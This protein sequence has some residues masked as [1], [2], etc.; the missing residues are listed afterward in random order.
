[1]F[2]GEK[3][4]KSRMLSETS[5]RGKSIALIGFMGAGKSTVGRL[6]AD[7]LGMP[8]LDLD[9]EIERETGRDVSEIFSREGEEG[10]RKRESRALERALAEGGVVIACGGGVVTVEENVA[11]LRERAVVFCL[12]V[13]LEEALRR[14][15]EGGK[16][17]PLLTGDDPAARARRL[18]EQRKEAYAA[19]AHEVIRADAAAPEEIAEEIARRWRRYG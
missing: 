5:A 3:R 13:S 1:M 14:T 15:E 9:A 19:A 8:F 12:E 10:F 18:L 7:R 17:R 16:A 11:L 4:E 2:P 6:L